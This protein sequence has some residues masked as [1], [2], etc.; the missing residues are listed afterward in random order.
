MRDR[1]FYRASL[2]AAVSLAAAAGLTAAA[3][4]QPEPSQ[5]GS[6]P[7]R[8]E[9]ATVKRNASTS[10]GGS[11]ISPAPGGRFVVTNAPLRHIIQVVY[12]V[13][14]YALVGGPDWLDSTRYD[15]E[16][17]AATEVP[18]AQA[19]SMMRDLLAERFK[20]AVH[21]E[22]RGT[23]GY[24]LVVARRD[25]RLGPSL[26]KLEADCADPPRPPGAPVMRAGLPPCGRIFSSD[27]SIGMNGRPLDE[28]A[29]ALSP[30]VGRP[31]ANRTGLEGNYVLRFQWAADLEATPREPLDTDSVSLF[32]AL[33][34]QLGLRLVGER[35]T[36]DVVVIEHVERPAEN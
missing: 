30:R 21:T 5:A 9:V 36:M 23:P 2:A 10:D 16:G 25:G 6:A 14:P 3:A 11:F 1:P 19:F 12:N 33:E 31:V 35:T 13:P 8:F 24:A 15:I 27:R 28:F 18:M 34:E 26:T 7:P 17:R 32:T 20:L 22:R 29:R 4:E